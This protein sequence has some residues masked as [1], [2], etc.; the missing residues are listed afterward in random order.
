MKV[1][2]RKKAARVAMMRDI[3]KPSP[4][5][6]QV[7]TGRADPKLASI[8]FRALVDSAGEGRQGIHIDNRVE[9]CIM[10]EPRD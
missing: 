8:P 3:R 10:D 9:I 7:P 5:P 4:D 1:P 6:R 2:N